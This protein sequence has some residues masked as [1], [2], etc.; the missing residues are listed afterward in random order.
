MKGTGHRLIA[1]ATCES[2]GRPTRREKEKKEKH[3][4]K[5]WNKK[6]DEEA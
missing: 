5:W 6:E 3:E 4:R 2:E 1:A